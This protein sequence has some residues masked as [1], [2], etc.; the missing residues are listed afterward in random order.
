MALFAVFALSACA[1]P[2]PAVSPAVPDPAVASSYTDG[3][4]P[5]EFFIVGVKLGWEG[6]KPTNTQIVGL[7]EEACEEI[8]A[9]NSTPDLGVADGNARRVIEYARAVYCP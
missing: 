7:G 9:G 1:S 3:Y 8:K 4:S 6:V 2:A 5:D